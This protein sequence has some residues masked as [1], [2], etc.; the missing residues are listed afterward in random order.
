M[1]MY[2]S[3]GRIVVSDPYQ[4]GYPPSA[5]AVDG[6]PHVGW[7]FG[8]RHDAFEANLAALGVRSTFRP[9]GPWGGA[10]VNFALPAQRLR[11]LDPGTL[12]VT[13]SPNPE[14]AAH[15]LDRDALTSWSSGG[16]RRGGEWIQVDLGRIEPVALVRWFPRVFQ[17]VPSGLRLETSLDGVTWRRLVELPEYTGPF[18]W[19]AG[20]P[21]LRVRSGRVELRVGPAPA[22]HL[23][24]TQTGA[25]GRWQWS[26]QELFVHAADPTEPP[27]LPDAEGAPLARAVRAAGV[28]RLYA[29]HGWSYRL[30][31][32]DP[33][34]LVPPANLPLDAYNF[35]GPDTELFP[36]VR[37]APE[38]GALVEPPHVPGFVRTAEASGL[39]VRR[40]DLGGLSLFAYTPPPPPPGRPIPPAE[41]RVTASVAAERAAHAAD[42]SRR[43]RWTTERA[44]TAGDW[45][46]VEP[47]DTPA[48]PGRAPV[49]DG[50]RRVAPGA[51][52]RRNR[53]RRRLDAAR[54]QR[55]DG[56]SR[57]L[58]RRHV[59]AGGY[60]R[61]VARGAAGSDAGAAAGADARR[62]GLP[63]V[64]PRADRVRRRVAGDEAGPTPTRL[65]C[66]LRMVY[67][68]RCGGQP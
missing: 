57:P 37:W 53:G 28:R 9:L 22:R 19:S 54:G 26:V 11:E 65:R 23:R 15:V 44:Q 58:G 50:V 39:G 6:A 2:L 38:A 8:G 63:L 55:T 68:R 13:A 33:E 41:L 1:L 5:R 59:A 12:R 29:D 60:H 61:R 21:M 27:T 4:E 52:P 43:M 31:L 10:Y 40:I 47:G 62:R 36:I 24:I 14:A 20:R 25:E 45:L 35:T 48:R 64:R 7:W 66:P 32:A 56:E 3:N 42:G 49:D 46:R 18:Y 17:E 67:C 34:L 16:P 30:A 51:P